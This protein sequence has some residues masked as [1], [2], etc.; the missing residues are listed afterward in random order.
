MTSPAVAT[1]AQMRLLKFVTIL[2]QSGCNKILPIT[3]GK[4]AASI[5]TTMTGDT[6][7]VWHSRNSCSGPK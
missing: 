6:V 1:A 4:V 3:S 5:A 2:V 7:I